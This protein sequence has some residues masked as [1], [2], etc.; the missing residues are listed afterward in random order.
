VR[1]LEALR[2]RDCA[3]LGWSGE[4]CVSNGYAV[5]LC[6]DFGTYEVQAN[7]LI[8]FVHD[9]RLR[10]GTHLRRGR[11]YTDAIPR[12]CFCAIMY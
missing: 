11:L 4:V 12:A 8:A 2:E 1:R 6:D 3:S 9:V 10:D 7:R 5:W